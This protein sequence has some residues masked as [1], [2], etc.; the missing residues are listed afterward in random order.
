MLLILRAMTLLACLLLI[1]WTLIFP[2]ATLLAFAFVIPLALLAGEFTR[3]LE[4]RRVKS[5]RRRL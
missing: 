4:L 1:V 2:L 5:Y 3:S